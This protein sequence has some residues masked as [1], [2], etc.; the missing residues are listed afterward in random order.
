MQLMSFSYIREHIKQMVGH[1]IHIPMLG[2][3]P[4]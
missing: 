4:Q 1:I 3:N 2:L